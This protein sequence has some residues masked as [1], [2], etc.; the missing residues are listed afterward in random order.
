MSAVLF[1]LRRT[2][3]DY[4]VE[5]KAKEKIMKSAKMQ[6]IHLP[7]IP[8][9][10]R[11]SHRGIYLRMCSASRDITRR[12]G[13]LFIEPLLRRIW[14]WTNASGIYGVSKHTRNL[15]TLL[16]FRTTPFQGACSKF[17]ASPVVHLKVSYLCVFRVPM[18]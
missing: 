11:H 15:S 8:A 18:P 9:L 14:I 6:R 10:A 16:V 7:R 5:L 3:I 4:A 13:A 17:F 2:R 12:A 1:V